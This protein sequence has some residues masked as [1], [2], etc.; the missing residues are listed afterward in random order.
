[1]KVNT[2]SLQT[3]AE[4]EEYVETRP[5]EVRN[6]GLDSEVIDI[7][8]FGNLE[9]D[10]I[11]TFEQTNMSYVNIDT[12][13]ED[14]LSHAKLKGVAAAETSVIFFN[15]NSFAINIFDPTIDAY[16]YFKSIFSRLGV[17]PSRS[18][19]DFM[20]NGKKVMGVANYTTD[21]WAGVSQLGPINIKGS[22]YVDFPDSKWE[23]KQY[24]KP[25]DRMT[26]LSE[27]LDT[28]VTIDDVKQELVSVFG[29]M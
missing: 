20:L 22:K 18:G 17:E 26:S 19:N 12:A 28:T 27:V 9:S 5:Q 4:L 24:N 11:I 7:D 15:Q 25:E 8:Y 29:G 10:I 1:M 2:V 16:S 21:A 14:G 13:L 23:D 6:K 3:A